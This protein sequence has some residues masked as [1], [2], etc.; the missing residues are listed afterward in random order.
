MV[1]EITVQEV[2]KAL[3]EH[4]NIIIIDVRE[5]HE[6]DAA[7]F[8]AIHIPMGEVLN[9][10]NEIPKDKPVYI[11]CRSGSRSGAICNALMNNGYTNVFNIKGGIMA[12]SKE[13][14]TSLQVM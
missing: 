3:D 7:N 4:Q 6:V 14:D 5:Q 2:K 8:G 13:I 10:L 12:W 9:R 1:N 11:H